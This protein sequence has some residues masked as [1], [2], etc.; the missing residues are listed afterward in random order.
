MDGVDTGS[1]PRIRGLD[2]LR[3]LAVSLVVPHHDTP[4][5]SDASTFAWCLDDRYGFAQAGGTPAL[6]PAPAPALR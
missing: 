2:T 4:F 5:V 6:S 1:A 3:A